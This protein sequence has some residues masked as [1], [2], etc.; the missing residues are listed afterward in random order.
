[1]A[2][3]AGASAQSI[4]IKFG[5]AGDAVP[6]ASYGG[7]GPAGV[8][9][10]LNATTTTI[11]GL[12]GSATGVQNFAASWG[13]PVSTPAS[14]PSGNDAILLSSSY[15]F[16]DILAPVTITGLQNGSYNAIFYGL[17]TGPRSTMFIA[18]DEGEFYTGSWTGQHQSGVSYV[19]LP[20]NVTN[21]TMSF[22]VV[23]SIFGVANWSAMQIVQVPGPGVLSVAAAGL[24]LGA[25]RRR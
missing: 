7:A 17:N 9:N 19:T 2:I 13:M 5:P 10:L 23:G 11:R 20:F 21:G 4:N 25:R 14:G 16:I 6:D 8:W 1:M 15:Q 22:G 24:V 18:G 3:G 12:D